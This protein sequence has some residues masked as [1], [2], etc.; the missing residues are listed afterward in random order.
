MYSLWWL[1]VRK[2]THHI[3]A[4][5]W[6][7]CRM[8]VYLYA[9]TLILWAF[10]ILYHFMFYYQLWADC[11]FSGHIIATYCCSFMF[12]YS[13]LSCHQKKVEKYMHLCVCG[14]STEIFL[15]LVHI[16][17]ELNWW[18]IKNVTADANKKITYK[19]N[20]LALG[21]WYICKEI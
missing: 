12:N 19:Y 13:K 17:S 2:I 5:T 21:Q 8:P 7:N 1:H 6:R 15:I 14:S 10:Q 3:K 16:L 11:T 4:L 9:M 18:H 20:I